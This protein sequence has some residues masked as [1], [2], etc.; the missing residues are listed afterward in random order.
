M[1][2]APRIDAHHHLWDLSIR[3]QPWTAELPAIHRSFA[4]DELAPQLAEAGVDGTVLVQTIAV[5]DETPELLALATAHQRIRGV[6]GWVDLTAPDVPERLAELRASPGG[7]RLVG[8]RHQVQGEPDPRWMLRP[9]VLAGLAAVAAAGLVYDLLV[10]HPQLPAAIEVVGLVPQ[11]RFVLDHAG[12]PP[13]AACE[14][15]PWR[16]RISAL[17]AHSNVAAKLSGLVTEDAVT[18]SAERIA[19]FAAHLLTAFGPDRVM[20]GSDWP[21][22]LLRGSYADVDA[23]HRALIAGLPDDDRHAVLGG[24]AMR[25]Y[26]LGEKP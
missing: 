14:L 12:K 19:P 3:D 1:I 26:G 20:V 6:V 5:P 4:F 9:D 11:L 8:V 16:A 10:I 13:I 17:A 25:W 7:N 2:T 21:V 18:W 23:L 24:T 22:C 15:D